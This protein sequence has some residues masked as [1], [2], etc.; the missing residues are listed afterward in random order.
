MSEGKQHVSIVITGTVDS[1]KS[2]TTGH[3]IYD[4]GGIKPR[5]MEKLK[6][7]AKRLGKDSFAFAFYMDTQKEER[8]RGITISC[9]TK[10]FFTDNYHYTVIDAPGHKD[11]IKNMITGA[12]QADVA[13]LMVPADGG[14]ISAIKK[15]NKKTGEEDGQTRHHSLLLNLLGIKQLIVCVNK[16]DEKTANYS[17]ERYEE[18]KKETTRMLAQTGWNKDV[19]KNTPIIPI[20]GWSGDNLIT[21][22]DKMPW[23]KGVDVQSGDEIAHVHTLLD[24]LNNMVKI[25]KRPTEAPLRMPISGIFNI[26]GVGTVITGRLEQGTISPGQEVK[27]FPRHSDTLP[28]TGKVFTVEMHHKNVPQAGPGDNVGINMKGLPKENM[29][30]VGDVMVLKND[31]TIGCVT[32]ITAM[33]QTLNIPNTI[34]TG[35]SPTGFV[36]TSRSAMKLAEIKKVRS[37]ETNGQWIEG[38]KELGSNVAAEV[39]FEPI[40]PFCCD[41][42]QNCE[43]LGRLALLEG[44]SCCAL[45]KITNVEYK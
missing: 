44:T 17:Q 1:G 16:M 15:A 19:I 31:N 35:Y 11:F 26:K 22:S 24:A 12:S 10:E 3:L 18:I 34:K 37:K 9:Q 42:F 5:D 39:V 29:P 38:I 45:G 6:E 20:S 2:T 7:E 28:C 25:P 8:E 33:I 27:F 30:K 13:V 21:E 41:T 32:R 36:R 43:G 40:K 23:W 4:L 14:F